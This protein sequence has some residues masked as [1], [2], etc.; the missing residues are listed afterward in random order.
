MYSV[1]VRNP[2]GEDT[3]DINVK[4]VG[5]MAR[6]HYSYITIQKQKHQSCQSR[7]AETKEVKISSLAMNI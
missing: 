7:K 5:E 4:V 6:P 3:A 2:A 1:V